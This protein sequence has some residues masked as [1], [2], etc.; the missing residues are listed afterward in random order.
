MSQYQK[1]RQTSPGEIWRAAIKLSECVR[2]LIGNAILYKM[3]LTPFLV[4]EITEQQAYDEAVL[5]YNVARQTD[6]FN[7]LN[8]GDDIDGTH[9]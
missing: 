5:D 2:F 4:C 1:Y 7:R 8:N 9:I 6:L 3:G